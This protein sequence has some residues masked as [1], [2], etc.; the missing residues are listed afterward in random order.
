MPSMPLFLLQSILIIGLPYGLWRLRGVRHVVPL[1]VVQIGVGLALGPSLLG[2]LAPDLWEHVFPTLSLGALN[3]LVWLAVTFFAFSTGLH[4][5]LAE[6]EGRGR[7]FAVTSISTVALPSLAGLLVGWGLYDWTPTAVGEGAHRLV[8]A[9]GVGI[10]VGVT[11]LPVLGAILREM[12]MLNT[13][14]GAEALGCA[15][16]NDAALWMMMAALLAV[17]GG[18]SPWR[19]GLVLAAA[20]AYGLVL[21]FLVKPL[22][23][24]L[25]RHAVLHGRINER[26]VV[27]LSV[28][29]FTSALAT[30]LIGIHAIV[31]AFA[32]GAVVPKPVAR[33][34]LAKF[35]SFLMVVLLPFFFIAT[36]LKTDFA[37][38]S[39]AGVV[40]LATTAVSVTAKL[41][42]GALPARVSGWS[43]R[44][45]LALGA[46][47]S[48]KGLMELV[49]LTLLLE[50]GILSSA[51]FSGMVLMA[52]ATTALA[53]PLANAFLKRRGSP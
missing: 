25:F 34:M 7:A 6:F 43:W 11:A 52:L 31:G 13:R 40:F 29:L 2:K 14:L 4:F 26:D 15:A 36:G 41:A 49:V 3:G 20:L 33:D 46:L 51:G 9:A 22:L 8:F 23:P 18:S 39:G 27:V 35:E 48:C 53:R 47:V 24:S 44:E 42:A 37:M 19:A 28:C 5:D 45:S 38:A 30:E 21:W 12:R 17:A 10:A 32:F 50:A 16:V 1:V